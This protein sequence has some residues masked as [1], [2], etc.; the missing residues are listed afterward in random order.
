[1]GMQI[2]HARRDDPAASIEHALPLADYPAQRHD[3]A[4]AN[5]DVAAIP[6]HP[7]A[8]NDCPP[9][10]EQIINRHRCFLLV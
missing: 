10:D 3:E 8:V 2:D 1:M 5:P 6:R 4:V 7:G 9:A